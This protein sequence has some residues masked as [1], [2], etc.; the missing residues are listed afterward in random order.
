VR[1][2]GTP[3]TSDRGEL[4]SHVPAARLVGDD[5]VDLTDDLRESCDR[6][7][8]GRVDRD[9]APRGWTDVVEL[10]ANVEDVPGQ[11]GCFDGAIG[12]AEVGVNR[13]GSDFGAPQ[14][15]LPR[16]GKG[17]DEEGDHVATNRSC[18]DGLHGHGSDDGTME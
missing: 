12:D 15:R 18:H 6:G 2:V 7:A 16:Q 8:A 9:A 3:D 11:N 10:T 5:G 4:T 17:R 14:D 13:L 1:Q